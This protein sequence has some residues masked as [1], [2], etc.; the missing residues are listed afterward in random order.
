MSHRAID[1]L[2]GQTMQITGQAVTRM[3]QTRTMFGRLSQDGLILRR[4][5]SE[6]LQRTLERRSPTSA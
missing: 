1:R 3:V 4:F 2:T 6:L 5:H